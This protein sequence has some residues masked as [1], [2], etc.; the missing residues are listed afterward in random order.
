M[1]IEFGVL[2]IV[3]RVLGFERVDRTPH[4][5]SLSAKGVLPWIRNP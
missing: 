5:D 2:A 3:Q 4:G 1:G